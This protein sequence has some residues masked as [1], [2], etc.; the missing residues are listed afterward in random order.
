MPEPDPYHPGYKFTNTMLTIDP[1]Y[2]TVRVTQDMDTGSTSMS[3]WLGLVEELVLN[4]LVPED[5]VY[6]VPDTNALTAYLNSDEAQALLARFCDT[7]DIYV[8]NGANYRGRNTDASDAAA[9]ELLDTIAFLPSHTYQ[10]WTPEEWFQGVDVTA[11]TSDADI[12]ALLADMYYEI[13]HIIVILS[14]DPRDYLVALRDSLIEEQ[15][16]E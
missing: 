6:I 10:L 12:D 1:R 16:Y 8:F 2:R 5:G 14:S 3:S 9:D 7:Y 13:D 15:E 4:F 11:A